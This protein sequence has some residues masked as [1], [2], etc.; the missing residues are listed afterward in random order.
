[1]AAGSQ[2]AEVKKWLDENELD[3]QVYWDVDRFHQHR[4]WDLD[5]IMGGYGDQKNLDLPWN[6]WGQKSLDLKWN[7]F[8]RVRCGSM[9]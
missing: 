8:R 7:I 3:L 9:K 1:M 4:N 2:R 6:I 5:E